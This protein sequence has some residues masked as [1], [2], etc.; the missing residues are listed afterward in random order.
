M[1]DFRKQTGFPRQPRDHTPDAAL[2]LARDRALLYTRGM[3]IDAVHSVEV[4][5]KS[6]RRSQAV[7][8]LPDGANG[9]QSPDAHGTARV[10]T[11]LFAIAEEMHLPLFIT[12]ARGNRLVSAPPMNRRPMIADPIGNPG[13]VSGIRRGLSSLRRALTGGGK[14]Q[15]PGRER[16]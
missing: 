13:I 4:A 2:S 9:G 3:D 16:P 11:A 14:P 10:M 15:K 12:D 5:L 1:G 8:I 7:E 6:L